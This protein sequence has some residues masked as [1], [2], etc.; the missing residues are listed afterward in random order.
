MVHQGFLTPPLPSAHCPP[1]TIIG[2]FE[3]LKEGYNK[4]RN[5]KNRKEW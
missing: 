3:N 2:Q 5:G 1:A 4:E